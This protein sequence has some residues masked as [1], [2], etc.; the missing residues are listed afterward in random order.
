MAHCLMAPG[1]RGHQ[2]HQA[3]DDDDDDDAAGPGTT[4]TTVILSE[5]LMNAIADPMRFE[6]LLNKTIQTW[7]QNGARHDDDED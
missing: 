3:D 2:Q 7:Q 4:N 5:A 6:T 1:P